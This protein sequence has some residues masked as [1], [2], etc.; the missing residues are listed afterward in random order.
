MSLRFL[1]PLLLLVITYS[2]YAEFVRNETPM[3]PISLGVE[4]DYEYSV[5]GVSN[6]TI[7]DTRTIPL[8]G[9]INFSDDG[10]LNGPYSSD[11]IKSMTFDAGAGN[12]I[13][14]KVKAFHFE[15]S[16]SVMYDHLGI[17][18]ST[19]GSSF[20]ELNDTVA[21]TVANW[22][23][24]TP[25]A[26]WKTANVAWSANSF[27][28]YDNDT[29]GNG[30]G[31]LF[32]EQSTDISPDD[33]SNTYPSNAINTWHT[34]NAR[35]VRFHFRS[36]A[37]TNRYGWNIDIAQGLLIPDSDDDGL[38]DRVETN[39]GIYVDASDT[40]TDPNDNDTDDDGLLDRVETNTGT[41]VDASD[42]GTNPNLADTSGDGLNDGIVV[43]A[44]FDPLI[45]Y[46]NFIGAVA[47]AML[48]AENNSGFATKEELPLIEQAGIDQVMANPANYDLVTSAEVTSLLN[49]R[50]SQSDYDSVVAER[51]A[52][53][54]LE[55]VAELRP[56]STMIE[57]SGNQATVQLQMEESSDLQ[58]WE[59]KGD[60]ATM[61]IPADTDTKFFRFKMTE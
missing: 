7:I 39:T 37:N 60:P 51:D 9:T 4:G 12:S 46:S 41:F 32:G 43:D 34:I 5:H 40:G 54:T 13:V 42:T 48:A 2:A 15:F 28:G 19:D 61:T 52:R 16:S 50:P 49:E 55:E 25:T 53:L 29:K 59:D 30:G 17:E 20:D 47:Q 33:N 26:A 11:Q 18:Y 23:Y 3:P 31:W 35:A 38:N 14:I 56:G 8:T 24:H 44:G 21:P 6:P 22:L 1:H 45:D 58:T 36:D 27:G 10:G 57:V